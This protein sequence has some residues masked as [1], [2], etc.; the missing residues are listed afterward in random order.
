LTPVGFVVIM[1]ILGL[2]SLRLLSDDSGGS[3]LTPL[4]V[5]AGRVRRYGTSRKCLK[6][7]FV[8][9]RGSQSEEIRGSGQFKKRKERIS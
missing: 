6:I 5:Y 7:Q 4:I 3:G 2:T 9:Q 1:D 8:V